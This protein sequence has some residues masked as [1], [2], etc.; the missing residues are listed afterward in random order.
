M[1][2]VARNV[3]RTVEKGVRDLNKTTGIAI[4]DL[5]KTTGKAAED[6]R[7]TIE[8]GL[9]DASRE[10]GRAGKN[11]VAETG[12]VGNNTVDI[13]KALEKFTE[14]N[15]DGTLDLAKS[16]EQRIREGKL[17]DAVFHVAL[18]PLTTQEEAA[19]LATQ[20][21]GYLN[22]AGAVA[23]GVYGGPGG[24]AAYAAWQTYRIS[25][26]NAE[27]AL[28]AG[29]ISGLSSA[30]LKGIGEIDAS[31]TIEMIEKSALAGAVGGLAIAASGGDE[32][33]IKNGFILG[34]GMVLIQD[35]YK[36]YTKHPLDPSPATGEPYCTSPFDKESCAILKSANRVE[37]GKKVFDTSKLNRNASHVGT[38]ANP[39]A[40]LKF[41]EKIPW[42]SDQSPLMRSA[43]KV[44]GMNAMGLF[45]DKLVVSWA[46]SENIGN[47][48]TIYP[49]MLFTYMGTDG[50]LTAKIAE[51]NAENS[52]SYTQSRN[53][54]KLD[55]KTADEQ[56]VTNTLTITDNQGRNYTI[57][58]NTVYNSWGQKI[59]T[60]NLP[61]EVLVKITQAQPSK[62]PVSVMYDFSNPGPKLAQIPADIPCGF[63]GR[64]DAYVAL[65]SLEFGKKY[66]NNKD[67]EDYGMKKMLTSK[68][69]SAPIGSIIYAR[70]IENGALVRTY[71]IGKLS[72]L[73]IDSGA[74]IVLSD[75]ARQQLGING[76][77]FWVETDYEDIGVETLTFKQGERRKIAFDNLRNGKWTLRIFDDFKT[78]YTLKDYQNTLEI[79][80]PIGQYGFDLVD[81]SPLQTYRE[82]SG[83]LVVMP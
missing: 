45:H 73:E 59:E 52:Q 36:N 1:K 21:S 81:E 24:S 18:D 66:L 11:I 5:A 39:D 25:G 68:H 34:G 26:G 41:G 30:A 43:A 29:I 13:F 49:A 78:L 63:N 9:A 55:A 23:A 79:N 17:L 62:P 74:T 70:N 42:S 46:I 69:R 57:M 54:E 60:Q 56:P 77:T 38:G 3:G 76:D 32:Q 83:I 15:I 71:V 14:K 75:P 67:W 80:L 8:K 20:Q 65:P 31:Q 61:N 58:N 51:V 7:K 44:P 53:S 72:Q 50:G 6:T 22:T 19:F 4:H 37:N 2:K 12:R 64:T 33:D 28:R 10:S 16:T 35:I 47:Q 27:L 40:P 48:L 82:Y